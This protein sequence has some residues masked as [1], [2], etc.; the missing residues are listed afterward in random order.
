MK[1]KFYDINKLPKDYGLLVFPISLVRSENGTGQDPVQCIEYLKHFSP[2][3]VSDPKIGVNFVYTDFLYMN[4]KEEA[5]Y[6]KNKF[7]KQ[8]LKH[9]NYFQKLIGKERQ[10]FQIQHAFSYQVWNQL[11]LDYEGDFASDFGILKKLYYSDEFF[12]KCVI[13][14]ISHFDKEVS[15]EQI[16]FFLEE[17][18]LMYLISKK[19]VLLR[20]EYIQGRQEWVLWCYPGKPLKGQ[21]YVYQNNPLDLDAPENPYQNHSYDLENKKLVNNLEI[22]LQTY[23][24]SYP[25]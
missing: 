6:L 13:D 8:N 25:E 17:H 14:D 24:Y 21:V 9:K 22:D 12:Q 18:L 4:S 5:I 19:K 15:E 7:T 16:N 11:Y 10:N 1:G 23:D 3:K 20:N 2:N